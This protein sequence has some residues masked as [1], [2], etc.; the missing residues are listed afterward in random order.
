MAAGRCGQESDSVGNGRA[1]MRLMPCRQPNCS[2]TVNGGGYCAQHKRETNHSHNAS[3]KIYKGRAWSGKVGI[4]PAVKARNP[5]CQKLHLV[6]G[7]LEQCRNWSFLVHHRNSPR[8]RPDLFASVF[9]ERGI[10]NL[11][12]LCQGCHPQS[13]GTPEWQEAR[14]GDVATHGEFFIKTQWH[15]TI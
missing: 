8:L 4:S 3:R 9:D 11:I 15:I 7:R 12:A 13:D 6:D 2:A 10:S 5:I 14:P 1:S